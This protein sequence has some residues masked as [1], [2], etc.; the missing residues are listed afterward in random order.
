MTQNDRVSEATE[1][2]ELREAKDRLSDA[3]SS[4]VRNASRLLSERDAAVQRADRLASDLRVVTVLGA[5][6]F[7][8]AFVA[9]MDLSSVAALEKWYG[10]PMPAYVR[11]ELDAALAAASETKAAEGCYACAHPADSY[12]T[13]ECADSEGQ[14]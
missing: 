1:L 6:G 14:L 8:L 2:A 9:K 3:W 7:D 12:G 4:C 11:Q 5:Y 10:V 13:H